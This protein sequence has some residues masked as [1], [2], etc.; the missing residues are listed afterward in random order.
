MLFSFSHT[1]KKNTLHEQK[2]IRAGQKERR[3]KKEVNRKEVKRNTATHKNLLG[4]HRHLIT[5]CIFNCFYIR[6]WVHARI[7]KAIVPVQSAWQFAALLIF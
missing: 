5:L 3:L 2:A 4:C 7:R 6:L 1:F